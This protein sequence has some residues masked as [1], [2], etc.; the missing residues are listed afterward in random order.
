LSTISEIQSYIASQEFAFREE[1]LAQVKKLRSEKSRRIV[2]DFLE[3]GR[4]DLA[5]QYIEDQN[6][7]WIPWFHDVYLKSAKLQDEK[8][9][10]NPTEEETNNNIAKIIAAL[11]LIL[12]NNQKNLL[13]YIWNNSYLNGQ[14]PIEVVKEW[15]KFIGLTDTQYRH[16]KE[17]EAKL[18]DN[19]AKDRQARDD[20]EEIKPLSDKEIKTMVDARQDQMLD[21]RADMDAREAISLIDN[22]GRLAVVNQ[23]LASDQEYEAEKEWRSRRDDRVRWTHDP[24][25]GLDGQK[26]PIDGYFN[27]PSGAKLFQPHDQGA[28]ISE[29]AN[30]RCYLIYRLKYKDQNYG[31]ISL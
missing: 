31:Q 5:L 21:A 18:K 25:G 22:A 20:G 29:T 14:S 4:I 27:S 10:F 16:L 8:F 9:P 7:T 11:L 15:Q 26:R 1:F 3:A 12:N 13:L 17:F 6:K 30:C 2:L 23:M 19:Q 28:P 24:H